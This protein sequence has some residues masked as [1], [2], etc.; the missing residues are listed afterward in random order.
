VEQATIG[1]IVCISG[2][3]EITIGDTI[4]SVDCVEPLPFVKISEPTIEMT[5]SVNDSPFAGQEGKYVTSR[6]LR[7]RLY[8][9][10]LKDVS[11]RVSDGETTD[12]FLVA[13]G[14]NAH[15][16][17]IETCAEK[18]MKS[19]SYPRSNFQNENGK[20]YEPIERVFT[21]CRRK[22]WL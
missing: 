21:K 3:P 19:P 4:T 5:F 12:N 8:R 9:E 22:A 2:I 20:K 10:T 15:F 14:R 16:I 1:D 11:L 6:Q 13:G 7:D 17:L 18:V